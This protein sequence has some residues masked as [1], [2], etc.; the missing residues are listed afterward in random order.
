MHIARPASPLHQRLIWVLWL[1]LLLP[2]A[3]AAAT[4]HVLS[5]AVSDL[6]GE[7][8]P[9]DG[10]RAIQHANCSLC[11]TAAALSSAAPAVSPPCPPQLT[12]LHQPAHTVLAGVWLA[13]TVAVYESRAPPS[14]LL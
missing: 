2:I 11:L 13:P 8:M 3:Q 10:K 4:F 12:A 7:G 6:A 1:V 14:S 9:A 5:H